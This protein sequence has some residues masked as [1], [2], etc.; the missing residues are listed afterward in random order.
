V[1]LTRTGSWRW[2]DTVLVLAVAV[3]AVAVYT[4]PPIPQAR[5]YHQF[6]D[7]RTLVGV[8]N[9]FDVLSNIPFAIVG[10]AGR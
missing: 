7:S 1:S 10:I 6:A 5:E 4:R 2:R 9:A 3:C 8:P